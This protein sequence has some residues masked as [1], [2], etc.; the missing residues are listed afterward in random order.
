MKARDFDNEFEF[1]VEH[2]REELDDLDQKGN[3]LLG[4]VIGYRVSLPHQCDEWVITK[5]GPF[6]RD[7]CVKEQAIEMMELFIEEAVRALGKLKEL[8]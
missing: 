6:E 1:K 5:V 8:E 3:P 4:E 7:A 2:I